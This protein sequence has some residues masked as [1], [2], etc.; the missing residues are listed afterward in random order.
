MSIAEVISIGSLLVALFALG[1]QRREFMR[2]Q[3]EHLVA[4]ARDTELRFTELREYIRTEIEAQAERND[5]K[6]GQFAP[7][8]GTLER[9]LAVTDEKLLH[10]MSLLN[11][12]RTLMN[13]HR[14]ET[15]QLI[16][17]LQTKKRTNNGQ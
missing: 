8:V 3:K 12:L 14:R 16:Q 1:Y 2:V 13:D 9:I 10:T 15:I 7:R 4:S 11:E 5:E 6:I 17:L